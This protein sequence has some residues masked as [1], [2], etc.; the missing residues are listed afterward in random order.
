MPPATEQQQFDIRQYVGILFFRWHI[1]A[2]C[3]LYCLLAGVL[4]VRFV[5]PRYKASATVEISLDPLLKLS[6]ASSTWISWR[7]QVV[8]LKSAGAREEVVNALAEDWGERIGSRSKM[9]LK[10]NASLDRTTRNRVAVNVDSENREYAIAFLEQLVEFHRERW[11]NRMREGMDDSVKLL[12]REL[13]NMDERI[14]DVEEEIIQYQR[15]HDLARVEARGASEAAYLQGLVSQR[16]GLMTQMMMMEAQFPFLKDANAG[17]INQVGRLT[18]DTIRNSTREAE[19]FAMK[20]ESASTVETSGLAGEVQE[21]GAAEETTEWESGWH[22]LRYKLMRLEKQE[23]QMEA[24]LKPEHPR[25]LELR[26]DIRELKRRVNAAAEL[27]KRKMMDRY[28]SLQITLNAVESAEYRWQAKY[29][30]LMQ[31]EAELNRIKNRLG[32]YE[33]NY[34]VL[35]ARLHDQQV[36]E[37]MRAERFSASKVRAGTKPIWPDPMKILLVAVALGLGSGFGLALTAQVLDNKIQSIKDVERDLGVPFLG[38]VPFW[39]HSGLERTI[40]PIV[41]EEHS[42][43]AIEAYRALR[44]SVLAALDKM[45]EK[46]LLVSSADSRE[47]KTLT[48]LNLAIMISQMNKKTLLV[49]LDMRRGRLH[50]S[51]SVPRDPG[52]T[53]VLQGTRSMADSVCKT[54]IEGLDIIPTGS[55]SEDTAELLQSTNLRAMFAEVEDL[56]DYIVCDTS[57]VLRVTDTVIMATQKLG[58]VVYVTRVNHTPKP[59]I[60]YSLDMLRDARVIGLIMN[61][62]EMHKISSLYYTYQYPNYAYYSNA[63]AYGYGY[64]YYGDDKESK[65]QRHQRKPEG[66]RGGMIAKWFR[67]TFL[68]VE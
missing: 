30:S 34:G 3:F 40:R 44:T 46:I 12:E 42:T 45:G 61:S 14:K 33:S 5:P 20:D 59:L 56:Y 26:K 36:T 43:G 55:T 64:Y 53:D 63:Y 27:Q 35:L 6:G 32:R 37:Q 39:V 7:R 24:D 67:R 23:E 50:R 41:T 15:L 13:A 2:V 22:E 21:P 58:A 16:R 29:L 10:V 66:G 48:A 65:R 54:R 68:P 47:G 4:Y 11:E 25:L 60:R 1:I 52:M 9:L 28:V 31:R 62:I 57:P 49:D 17:V 18:Q 19:A 51:L 8:M 38:G